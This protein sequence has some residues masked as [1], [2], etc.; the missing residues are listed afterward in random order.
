MECEWRVNGVGCEWRVREVESERGMS[1]S[2]EWEREEC[3]ERGR[4]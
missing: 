3:E 4:V 1:V 2:G